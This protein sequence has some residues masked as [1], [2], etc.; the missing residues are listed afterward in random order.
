MLRRSI[1]CACADPAANLLRSASRA[2]SLSPACA[3][4]AR[5]SGSNGPTV[6][7]CASSTA[8]RDSKALREKPRE[9]RQRLLPTLALAASPMVLC[10]RP[11]SDG[12]SVTPPKE[13]KDRFTLVRAYTSASSSSTSVG[14]AA[15]P[16]TD[17]DGSL[18][19]AGPGQPILDFFYIKNILLFLVGAFAPLLLLLLLLQ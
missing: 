18:I 13:T 12:I 11:R 14:A 16:A 5:S 15:E 9:S 8:V 17:D 3:Q 19:A 10:C 7:L 2:S 6:A 1:M 4:K